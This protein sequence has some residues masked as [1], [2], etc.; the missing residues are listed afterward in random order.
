[1]WC[2]RGTRAYF[3]VIGEQLAADVDPPDAAGVRLAEHKRH[4]VRVR[5][6]GIHYDAVSA[7][8][9]KRLQRQRWGRCHPVRASTDSGKLLEK[10]RAASE[11]ARQHA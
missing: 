3:E 11:G 5:K 9:V 4:N 10:E 6:T 1:M 2:C 7:P 8:K